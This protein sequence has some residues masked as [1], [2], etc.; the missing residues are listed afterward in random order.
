MEYFP[1]DKSQH[2]LVRQSC[3]TKEI[4]YI[5]HNNTASEFNTIYNIII[6]RRYT[7]PLGGRTA[8]T[9]FR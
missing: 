1:L 7:W 2:M 3:W 8:A 6:G 9:A 4:K 5:N